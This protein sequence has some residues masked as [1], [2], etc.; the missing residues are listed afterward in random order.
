MRKKSI[1][2]KTIKLFSKTFLLG[3][4]AIVFFF[5]IEG[6]F[7]FF[8]I[9][10]ITQFN[11]FGYSSSCC[12]NLRP[13]LDVYISVVHNHPYTLKTNNFGLRNNYDIEL[14][15]SKKRVLAIGDSFTFGPYLSNKETYTYYL[16]EKYNHEVE[17]LNAGLPGST[18]T[19]QANY[20]YNKGIK[21]NPDLIILQVLSNDISDIGDQNIRSYNY[22]LD[23]IVNVL[24]DRSH[25]W[26]FLMNIVKNVRVNMAINTIS[27]RSKQI[28]AITYLSNN[29]HK[30]HI[31]YER[32][33]VSLID[34]LNSKSTKIVLVILP[35]YKEIQYPNLKQPNIFFNNLCIKHKISC[36][37][38]KNIFLEYGNSNSLYLRPWNNHLS[39]HG[40]Q[41]L[42]ERIYSHIKNNPQLKG[43]KYQ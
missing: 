31:E 1:V 16:E 19:H 22:F 33:L 2:N 35:T 25:I 43:G 15:S 29:K 10:D 12:G 3:A 27:H 30:Y 7:S 26:A 39:K 34:F 14:E 38:L 17:I 20:I 37:D 13:N 24:R 32:Q 40:N 8:K 42:A 41:L 6:L 18:V 9:G 21:L 23:P 5:V 36:L 4:I 28:D 11:G